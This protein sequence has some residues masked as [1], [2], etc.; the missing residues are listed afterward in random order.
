MRPKFFEAVTTDR[1]RGSGQ[2]TV[3][4]YDGLFKIWGGSLASERL[5]HVSMIIQKLTTFLT[6][7]EA[8]L[9]IAHQTALHAIIVIHLPQH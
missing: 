2:I 1:I 5:P 4:N 6:A 8:V 7:P 9:V 3:E